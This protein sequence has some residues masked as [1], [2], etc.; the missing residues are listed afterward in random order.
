M[1]LP[2][3]SAQLTVAREH[4]LLGEYS[5]AMVYYAGLLSQIDRYIPS[6]M[7]VLSTPHHRVANVCFVCRHM[8]TLSDAY[9]LSKWRACKSS[10]QAEH[11]LVGS[12][13]KDKSA[14]AK[15]VD[16]AASPASR[17]VQVASS[18]LAVFMA[19]L[20]TSVLIR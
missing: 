18:A 19:A 17:C 9:M 5:S 11:N 20:S 2:S 12:I 3:V 10:L 15:P 14:F 7:Q 8:Q 16:F 4:A 1:A 13:H 6:V